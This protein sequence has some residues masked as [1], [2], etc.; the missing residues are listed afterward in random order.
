MNATFWSRLVRR[1]I[2]LF[3]RRPSPARRGSHPGVEA[4]EDRALLSA[5]SLAVLPSGLGAPPAGRFTTTQPRNVLVADF[6]NDHHLDLAISHPGTGTVSIHLGLGEGTFT[7]EMRYLVGTSP[8]DLAAADL[9]GDSLL[10]L[11]VTNLATSE[12]VVLLGRGDGTFLPE[13]AFHGQEADPVAGAGGQLVA[14]SDSPVLPFASVEETPSPATDLAPAWEG[15]ARGG[16]ASPS[17]TGLTGGPRG[18]NP[19]VGDGPS[20]EGTSAMPGAEG[21]LTFAPLPL[22]T[23]DPLSWESRGQVPDLLPLRD[24]TLAVVGTLLSV[25]QE[26]SAAAKE[27]NSAALPAG[28]RP[29]KELPGAVLSR[30]VSG[31]EEALENRPALTR[32]ELLGPVEQP[33]AAPCPSS[34][35]DLDDTEQ[36]PPEDTTGDRSQAGLAV[37]APGPALA[38]QL[39]TCG[40]A[41]GLIWAP[42]VGARLTWKSAMLFASR[43]AAQAF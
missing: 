2:K 18:N 12:V 27:T 31:Q 4:L 19:G 9:N 41:C 5:G 34:S 36:F 11:V 20:G 25:R 22:A 24:S 37:P 8:D 38:A 1:G 3:G 23:S 29:A 14:D 35:A 26:D 6:N 33:P 43:A 10:D 39:I 42:E 28:A 17:S 16:G 15:P 21:L 30:F 7:D 13:N 40:L 32:E